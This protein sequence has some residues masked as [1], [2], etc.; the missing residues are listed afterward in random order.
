MENKGYVM[1]DNYNVDYDEWYEEFKD[2]CYDNDID[3]SN[4]GKDSENFHNWVWNTLN[5]YW[6]DFIYNLQHDKDN[7]VD[8]VVI[9]DLGLWYGRR[10]CVKHFSTLESAIYA[11]IKDCDYITITLVD[12]IIKVRASHHD[13]TNYFE[14]HKLNEK[15]YD[16]ECDED[17][18]LNNEEYFDKFCVQY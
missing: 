9:A 2:W 12:G 8:C 1:Y 14:I 10:D 3:A 5:M 17:D 18:D 16:A 4:Y 11:C 7:N 13:G 15:G 6:D